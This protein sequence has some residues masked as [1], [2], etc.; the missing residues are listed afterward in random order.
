[1]DHT[2]GRQRDT[3]SVVA[4]CP[5]EIPANGPRGVS[6]EIDQPGHVREIIVEEADIRRPTRD[7]SPAAKRDAHIGGGQGA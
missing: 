1:M 6:G 7:I 3:R 2:S 4:E 5:E